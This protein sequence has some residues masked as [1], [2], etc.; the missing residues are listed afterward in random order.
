M[1]KPPLLENKKWLDVKLVVDQGNEAYYIERDGMY[2]IVVPDALIQC[3][4]PTLAMMEQLGEEGAAFFSKKHITDFETNYKPK[5]K[6]STLSD[7]V[8]DDQS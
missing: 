2:D 7:P 4:I 6:R 5:F 8:A 3:Q 1:A